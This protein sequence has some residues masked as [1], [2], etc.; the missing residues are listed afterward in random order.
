MSDSKHK[1]PKKLNALRV[2]LKNINALM[3]AKSKKKISVQNNGKNIG[4]KR[5]QK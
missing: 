2:F 3:R 4:Q 5:R 1:R